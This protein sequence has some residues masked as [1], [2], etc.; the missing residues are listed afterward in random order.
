M[1][2]I[3]KAAVALALS[4]PVVSFAQTEQ[5]SLT[6][7]QV[8]ADVVRAESAGYAPTAWADFPY[9]E[10]QAAEFR[11]ASQRAAADPAGYGASWNGRS[12]FGGIAR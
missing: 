12:Q 1:N 4:A 9:G 3:V 8:R 5:S 2:S 10:V 6:R 11:S 7:A